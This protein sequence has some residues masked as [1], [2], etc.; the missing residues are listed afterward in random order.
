MTNEFREL[1]YERFLKSGPGSLT[2]AELLGVMLRTGTK[3]ISAVETG[4]RILEIHDPQ[5]Q[6]LSM[7]PKLTMEELRT[8]PG[9][10]EVKAIKLLCLSEITRRIVREKAHRA[11]VLNTPALI[12]DLYMEDMRHLE[13]ERIVVLHLDAKMAFLGEDVLSTG[14]VN[15]APISPREVFLKALERKAVQIVLIHNHPSGDPSPSRDD[16]LVTE[17]IIRAGDLLGIRLTDHI[18]IG[19]LCYYSFKEMGTFSNE[20]TVFQ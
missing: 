3:G 9:I 8:I 10:G 12:A 6:S 7:L 1:P 15:T 19:D 13:T 14:S 4:R 16:V 20:Q 11:P 2:N 5:G 18:I 17:E